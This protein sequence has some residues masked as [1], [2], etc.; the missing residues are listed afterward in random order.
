M[1]L[2]LCFPIALSISLLAGCSGWE[3]KQIAT[4]DDGT[5]AIEYNSRIY[6]IKHAIITAQDACQEQGKNALFRERRGGQYVLALFDCV[7]PTPMLIRPE[8]DLNISRLAD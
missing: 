6:D 5:V 8:E 2:G 4:E 3:P 7:D 1:R